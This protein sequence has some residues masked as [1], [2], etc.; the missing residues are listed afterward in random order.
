MEA[1]GVGVGVAPPEAVAAV[2]S[3]PGSGGNT[4]H[5][6]PVTLVSGASSAQVSLSEGSPWHS[7]N[8]FQQQAGEQLCLANLARPQEIGFI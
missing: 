3:G 4:P 2:T 1:S 5:T 6:I 7:W 8:F